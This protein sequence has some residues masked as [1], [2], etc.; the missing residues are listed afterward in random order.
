VAAEKE[1]QHCG[2]CNHYSSGL[3]FSREPKQQQTDQEE[4][5]AQG[6]GEKRR[7]KIFL[8]TIIRFPTPL[9]QV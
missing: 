3:L 7:E 8:S 2:E 9:I 5:N 1:E 6:D 4:F